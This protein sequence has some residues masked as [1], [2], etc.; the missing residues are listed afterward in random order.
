MIRLGENLINEDAIEVVI[1][2]RGKPD[3]HVIVT[4]S[5]KMISVKLTP[6]QLSALAAACDTRFAVD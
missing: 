5:G 2:D 6:E 1:P 3:S 4:T